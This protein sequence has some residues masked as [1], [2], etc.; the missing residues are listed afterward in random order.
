MEV[1]RGMVGWLRKKG[2]VQRVYRSVVVHNLLCIHSVQLAALH[3]ILSV[4]SC[5]ALLTVL[6]NNIL[7]HNVL[8]TYAQST[9][10]HES[11]AGCVGNI[12]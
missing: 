1:K 11:G 8:H 5:T 4:T 10:V 3:L 6:A 9:D 12:H 2:V 7:T